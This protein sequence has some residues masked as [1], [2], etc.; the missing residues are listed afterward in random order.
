MCDAMCND[1]RIAILRI[2]APALS[3]TRPYTRIALL[4]RDR[5]QAAPYERFVVVLSIKEA[6]DRIVPSAFRR[7]ARVPSSR[8]LNLLYAAGELRSVALLSLE[9]ERLGISAAGLN[10]S[11]SGIFCAEDSSNSATNKVETKCL[12]QQLAEHLVVIVP[13]CLATI[14]DRAIVNRG[15][16]G[17]DLSAVLLAESLNALRCEFVTQVPGL[18][19]GLSNA[20]EART[21]SYE[22]GLDRALS[23]GVIQKNVL[24]AALSGNIQVVLTNFRE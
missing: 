23:S 18:G 1:Y 24:D 6:P 21:V 2:N 10:H 20:I 3:R 19:V 11:E 17:A 5:C 16:A 14:S 4:V 7:F 9:L 12:R 13:G 8:T 22:S 15:P